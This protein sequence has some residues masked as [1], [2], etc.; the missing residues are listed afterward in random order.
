MSVLF[1]FASAA[2]AQ[3]A[4]YFP[5]Q[6]GNQWIYRVTEGRI[7][8]APWVV[9]VT[10]TRTVAGNEYYVVSGFRQPRELLLRQS[11]AALV[12][13]D[14]ASL[15]ELPWADFG[16]PTGR[17]FP[18]HI[19]DCV[20]AAS[21]TE[22]DARHKSPV[23]EFSGAIKLSYELTC[24]DA[25]ITDEVF[26]PGVGL[27]RRAYSTIGGPQVFELVYARVGGFTVFS[28]PGY[29]FH[30]TLD[31][32]SYPAGTPMLTRI[33]LHNTGDDPLNLVFPSGQDFDIVMRNDKGE[34]VYRWSDGKAFT[35]A[36]REVRF[37]GERNWV[38][39]LAL[40]LPQGNYT[41]TATL[42]VQGA[43][44]ESTVPFVVGPGR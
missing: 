11:G 38:E 23:G 5:L 19:D 22:R 7:P 29:A 9:E 37:K 8:A 1:L 20:Q 12:F 21:I 31:R 3:E 25:G 44:Y 39:Q 24:A 17:G 35:L 42:A 28:E 2:F 41:A 36:I 16:A 33:T 43:R 40:T 27:A 18:S 10:G 32:A 4:A 6:T 30:L 26:L 13:Y 34:Q 14:T 15:R